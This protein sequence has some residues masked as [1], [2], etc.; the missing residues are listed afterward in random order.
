MATPTKRPLIVN[1]KRDIETRHSPHGAG[2]VSVGC[3]LEREVLLDCRGLIT[4][5]RELRIP[6]VV[7]F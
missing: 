4:D 6:H 5:T 3:N 1:L 7:K 2:F